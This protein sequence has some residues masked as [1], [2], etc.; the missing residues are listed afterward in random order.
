MEE[1]EV[2]HLVVVRGGLVVGMVSDRDIL[3]S[4]GW[5]LSR[6]R[7]VGGSGFDGDGTTGPSTVQ[8]IMSTPAV[9]IQMHES[10]GDAAR[11]MVNRKIGALPIMNEGHLAGILTDSDLMKWLEALGAAEASVTNFLSQAVDTIMRASVITVAPET[12]L[13]EVTE[14]FRRHRIRHVPVLDQGVLTGI[15]SDRDVRRSLGWAS[16]RQLQSQSSES[17]DGWF[18][19]ARDIMQT[20]VHWISRASDLGNALKLMLAKRVHS[21]P[22][23]DAG[24][25]VGI[26]THADYI[27]AISRQE[28]L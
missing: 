26:V 18:S 27:K 9:C 15:I 17:C 1:H 14:L 16:V 28:L 25:L 11:L 19:A 20:K 2:H 21:L 3:I 6:E 24:K 4:T 22:I 8:E 23:L 10:A 12:L 13:T 5:M 7:R